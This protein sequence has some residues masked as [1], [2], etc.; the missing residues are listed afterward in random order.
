MLDII[1]TFGVFAVVLDVEA[2]VAV[3]TASSG[4]VSLLTE[5]P[6]AEIAAEVDRLGVSVGVTVGR[7]G[8]SGFLVDVPPNR[9]AIGD[10]VKSSK[11]YS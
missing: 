4:L 5:M 2:T 1:T 9:A 6:S 11:S 10:I 3:E 8:L 7:K